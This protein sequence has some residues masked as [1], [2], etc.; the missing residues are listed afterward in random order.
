M[1]IMNHYLDHVIK[2]EKYVLIECDCQFSGALRSPGNC[3]A[4]QQDRGDTRRGEGMQ[5][6]GEFNSF[7]N[8]H[9][10]ETVFIQNNIRSICR[11]LSK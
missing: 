3:T 5:V 4:S 9:G 2:W 1:R 11:Q 8:F 6:M 10:N 7:H